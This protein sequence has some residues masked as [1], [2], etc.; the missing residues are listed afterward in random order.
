MACLQEIIKVCSGG[1][2]C[3]PASH[4][5][6]ETRMLHLLRAQPLAHAVSLQAIIR[7]ISVLFLCF[8]FYKSRQDVLKLF[9]FLPVTT[10]SAWI[11]GLCCCSLLPCICWTTEVVAIYMHFC[12]WRNWSAWRLCSALMLLSCLQFAVMS[13]IIMCLVIAVAGSQMVAHWLTDIIPPCLYYIAE[14]ME[15]TEQMVKQLLYIHMCL[16]VCVVM[17]LLVTTEEKWT[18]TTSYSD[19]HHTDDNHIFFGVKLPFSL[20]TFTSYLLF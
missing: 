7:A 14:I 12:S 1:C 16:F 8:V 11:I 17:D 18:F 20:S 4:T 5:V 2:K 13:F 10:C 9:R 3:P 19:I 6:G 15:D